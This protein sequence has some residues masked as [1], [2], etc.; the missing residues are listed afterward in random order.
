MRS[1][2]LVVLAI[3]SFVVLLASFGVVSALTI[4]ALEKKNDIRS[5][6]SMGAS[7][8]LLRA[9][10]FKNGMLIVGSGWLL[11]LLLG[12]SLILSQQYIGIIPLGSG[13]VQEYYPVQLTL[14][15]L[16]LTSGIVLTIGTVLSIWA[17]RNVAQ[18]LGN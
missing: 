11:G 15:H 14:E 2:R 5:L 7:D 9:V 13:Y 17:T 12:I 10:F 6:W 18:K 8:R 3:L 16:L 1:E 4:I